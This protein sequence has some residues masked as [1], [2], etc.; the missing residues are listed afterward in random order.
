MACT[1]GRV[2]DR[3]ESILAERCD[4]RVIASEKDD[5]R[6]VTLREAVQNLEGGMGGACGAGGEPIEGDAA[7]ATLR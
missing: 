1:N 4:S 3:H 6:V 7:T 5:I 2:D